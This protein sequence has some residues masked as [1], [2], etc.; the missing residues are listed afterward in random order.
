M[1]ESSLLVRL[2]LRSTPFDK[3][4]PS[5]F[6]ILTGLTMRLGEGM[7]EPSLLKEDILRYC[8]YLVKALR[9]NEKF[10]TSSFHSE[11]PGD[12]DLKDLQSGDFVYQKRHQ[13]K[14]SL[15][16]YWKGPCQALLTKPCTTKLKGINSWI[17]ISYF[18]KTPPPEWTSAPVSDPQL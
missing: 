8:Q 11:L 4:Q 10:V 17:H 15:Q 3:H 9:K 1:A 13:I 5:P 2:N 7:Y 12:T 18:K 16:P 6:E 14:N